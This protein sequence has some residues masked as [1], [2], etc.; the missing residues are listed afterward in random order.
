MSEVVCETF[1]GR[2][3]EDEVKGKWGD[4]FGLLMVGEEVRGIRESKNSGN[5]MMSEKNGWRDEREWV[6]SA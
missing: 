3:R 4:N 6:I 5:E 2:M 1:E